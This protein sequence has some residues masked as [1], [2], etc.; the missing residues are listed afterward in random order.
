[1]IERACQ[2]FFQGEW[3]TQLAEPH[4]VRMFRPK[5]LSM[6][7]SWGIRGQAGTYH[8]SHVHSKGWYS[9]TC[10]I[11]VPEILNGAADAGCLIFGE[12]PFETKDSLPPAAVIQP[13]PGRLVLFPSYFWHGT[14][15]YSGEGFRQV[16]A[17]DFGTPNRFV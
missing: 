10:Y 11:E 4:P 8:Q 5:H 2:Q 12:P 7:A 9:G 16:V 15:T 17:F 13:I 3:L 14:R 1:M 6:H